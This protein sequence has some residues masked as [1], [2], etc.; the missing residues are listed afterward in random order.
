LAGAEEAAWQSETASASQGAANR[1]AGAEMQ[2][3]A[4]AS[5]EPREVVSYTVAD[6]HGRPAVY[7]LGSDA[8]GLIIYSDDGYMSAQLMR[9]DRPMFDHVDG[10]VP[11]GLRPDRRS[12]IDDRR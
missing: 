8:T 4:L 12:T 1:V 10:D 2:S 3:A 6:S 9:A 7:P 5:V 11:V